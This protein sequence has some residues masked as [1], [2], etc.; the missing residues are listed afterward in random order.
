[1]R[2]LHCVYSVQTNDA[3]GSKSDVSTTVRRYRTK[4][5]L[6]KQR[7]HA[8]E[9]VRWRQDPAGLLHHVC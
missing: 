8:A 7:I 2:S 5:K 9:L 6:L 3:L 4:Y 1:M